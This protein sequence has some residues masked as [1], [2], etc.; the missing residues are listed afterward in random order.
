M[1]TTFDKILDI[2]QLT[3]SII[4]VITII[5]DIRSRRHNDDN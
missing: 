1:N 3:T 2:V 5:Y 4:L